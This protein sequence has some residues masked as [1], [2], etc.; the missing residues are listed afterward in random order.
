MDANNLLG[1]GNLEFPHCFH[2]ADKINLARRK[3][4]LRHQNLTE[5]LDRA[6]NATYDGLI[7]RKK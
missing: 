3:Y 1:L 4:W 5:G 7:L 6:A 2:R